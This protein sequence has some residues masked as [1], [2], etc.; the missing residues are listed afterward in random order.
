[1]I[2][3]LTKIP[4]YILARHLDAYNPLPMSLT[5]S[6][7]YSC[8]SRCKT[9]NVWKKTAKNFTLDEYEKTFSSLG[10]APYWFTMS[11]GEPFLRADIADV[12]KLAH[13][14]C[15]PGI[16][17][18]PTNGSLTDRITENLPKILKNCPDSDVV[19]NL[20]LDQVGEKHDEIR[21]IPHNF[22]KSMKTLAM[23]K[24]LRK[25]YS[26][27]T[28]G[29]HSV[30]SNFNVDYITEIYSQLIKLG[31]DS[32]IT[33]IAE[34][35]VELGTIGAG[36]TPTLEKYTKAID[37]LSDRIKEQHFSGLGRVTRAFRLNYYKMVK[38]VL[39]EKRQII[40]CYAGIASA[41]I[42]PDGD[43]WPCCIRAKSIGNLRENGYDFKKIWNSD[44]A[45]LMRKSIKNKECYC[46]LANSSYTNMLMD[47]PTMFKV[48]TKFLLGK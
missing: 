25:E 38:D 10:R 32:Y 7:L 21:G 6:L 5:V 31:A 39:R 17:N 27:F 12:C 8:N 28:V 42:S 35:R 46:P 1:M 14:I 43:V 47:M 9:C 37:F 34:E 2:E 20:S 48:G 26:N 11:G 3:I 22:E 30:V 18:I 40:P 41:Q 44:E 15:H 4:R 13:D 19:V 45:R 36:I 16:I 29:I 24:E 23:M 33:E